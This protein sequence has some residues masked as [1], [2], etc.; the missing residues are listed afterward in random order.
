MYKEIEAHQLA[1][2]LLQAL[3]WI[4]SERTSA[5]NL[6]SHPW[7]AMPDDYQPKMTEI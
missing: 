4:P 3:K 5:R 7:L 2:F 1:D 6:L